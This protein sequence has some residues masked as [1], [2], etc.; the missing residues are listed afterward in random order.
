MSQT[1]L[2][3]CSGRWEL[4]PLLRL[5]LGAMQFCP[6]LEMPH[7]HRHLFSRAECMRKGEWANPR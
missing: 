7:V 5:L 1:H 3:Q 2:P 4:R 6:L